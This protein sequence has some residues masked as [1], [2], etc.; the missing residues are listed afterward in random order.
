M[1]AY[2]SHCRKELGLSP[3]TEIFPK[4]N[5]VKE[6]EYGNGITIPYRAYGINKE[7]AT[8]GLE[9]LYLKIRNQKLDNVFS[10]SFPFQCC[11]ADERL[12]CPPGTRDRRRSGN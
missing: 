5:E 9:I 7:E 11:E 12:C 8:K 4:Q 6:D 3:K 10:G 2:L 1:R